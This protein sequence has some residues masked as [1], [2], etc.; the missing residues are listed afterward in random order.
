MPKTSKF[1]ERLAVLEHE[2]WMR[3]A[4]AVFPEVSD[5]RQ[6]R[7]KRYLVP[8]EELAEQVKDHDREWADKVL[9][10]VYDFVGEVE[11]EGV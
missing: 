9:D 2:Q 4:S 11:E 3:W 1:R 6:L 8:Y 7:W 10:I 5:E